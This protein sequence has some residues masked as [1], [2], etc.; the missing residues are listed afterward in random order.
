MKKATILILIAVY[1]GSIFVV[2]IFGMKNMPYEEIVPIKTIIP[3]SVTL[4]S[5]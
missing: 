3:T 2:G 1:L 4:S 5:G